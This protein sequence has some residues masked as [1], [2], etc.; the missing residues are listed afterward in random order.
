M[1]GEKSS[2]EPVLGPLAT[3]H[4]ADL[5]LGAGE[6]SDTLIHRMAFDAAADGRPL[7]VLTFADCDPSGWQMTTSIARKLQA[8]QASAAH[9]GRLVGA[10]RFRVSG[11]A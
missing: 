8:L 11:L 10:F 6:T 7:V 9:G 4:D 3:R 2:L 1:W 5:Y